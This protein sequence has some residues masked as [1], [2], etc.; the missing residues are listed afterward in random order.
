MVKI[1]IVGDY[2]KDKMIL[3]NPDCIV[4]VEA[5]GLDN[6]NLYL[7]DGRVLHMTDEMFKEN[8]TEEDEEDSEDD[9]PRIGLT[10]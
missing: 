1:K 3:V 8:F 2:G 4:S 7:S 10:I 6:H 9:E 5:W